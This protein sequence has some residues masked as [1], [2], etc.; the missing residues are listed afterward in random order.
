MSSTQPPWSFGF[1]SQTRGPRENGG[2]II[3]SPET[4]RTM[5]YKKPQPSFDRPNKT[6]KNGALI[7]FFV[8]A[9]TNKRHHHRGTLDDESSGTAHALSESSRFE[10][11]GSGFMVGSRNALDD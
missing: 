8:S 10:Q 6:P 11:L 3:L 9:R 1:D 2:E 4:L 7:L 5:K